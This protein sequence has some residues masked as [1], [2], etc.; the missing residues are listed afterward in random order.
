MGFSSDPNIAADKSLVWTDNPA[1]FNNSLMYGLVKELTDQYSDTGDVVASG[2]IRYFQVL[3]PAVDHLTAKV[4]VLESTQYV[5][6]LAAATPPQPWRMVIE[7]TGYTEGATFVG[8]QITV[9]LGTP[10]TIYEEAGVWHYMT[11]N[12]PVVLIQGGDSPTQKRINESNLYS[13]RVSLAGNSNLADKKRGVVVAVWENLKIEQDMRHFGFFCVQRPVS[14]TG[15]PNDTGSAPV[16]AVH[17]TRMIDGKPSLSSNFYY[18]ILRERFIELATRGIEVANSAHA[19]ATLNFH[20]ITP[21]TSGAY[22]IPNPNVTFTD[23]VEGDA[24]YLRLGNNSPSG[25]SNY[26]RFPSSLLPTVGRSIWSNYV[27][28]PQVDASTLYSTVENSADVGF[29]SD[30]VVFHAPKLV[31]YVNPVTKRTVDTWQVQMVSRTPG[32]EGNFLRVLA[33][34]VEVAGQV[35]L[36]VWGSAP[37]ADGFVG[38]QGGGQ[39]ATRAFAT[40]RFNRVPYVDPMGTTINNDWVELNGVR[41]TFIS[42]LMSPAQRQVR[43]GTGANAIAD[44]I[45]NLINEIIRLRHHDSNKASYRYSTTPAIAGM[46]DWDSGHYL[47]IE[48]NAAGVAGNDFTVRPNYSFTTADP[49]PS[50]EVQPYEGFAYLRLSGGT[51]WYEY[52]DTSTLST[53]ISDPFQNHGSIIYPFPKTWDAPVTTDNDEYVLEFPF[54]FC[55]DKLA[56]TEEM[57][58][59][60]VSK[61]MAYQARQEVP[62]TV[63]GEQRLYTALAINKQD[64]PNNPVRLFIL[65]SGGNTKPI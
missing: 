24:G 32:E 60:A 65:T 30:K 56:F 41:F 36:S 37:D 46:T 5:N 48:H 61:G 4:V 57:D 11:N 27:N 55:T 14:S 18:S 2:G 28:N 21:P 3:S 20:Y 64:Y 54:G 52:S 62:I 59:I 1:D 6:H 22:N 50:M 35:G 58:M 40:I 8:T 34:D 29:F 12:V 7:T 17:N 19:T 42:P 15:Q 13:Y 43:I 49:V 23:A 51:G 45:Q 26:V 39:T 31:Q 44:T 10:T 38:F 53:E 9:Y 63:Y 47:I 33:T 25:S 16:V